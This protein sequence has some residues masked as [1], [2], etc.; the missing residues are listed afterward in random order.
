MN[1]KLRLLTPFVMLTA[2]AV[3]GIAMFL[4]RYDL[5]STLPVLLL[6]L[7]CFLVLGEILTRVIVRFVTQNE[8]ALAEMEAMEGD[9]IEM[10][11][12]EGAFAELAEDG[13]EGSPDADAFQAEMLRSLM[14]GEASGVDI[15][16]DELT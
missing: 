13:G 11:P 16:E 4:M 10:G 6:A 14:S 1:D 8:A 7:L 9:V 15:A 3:V 12:D 5:Q 2:G